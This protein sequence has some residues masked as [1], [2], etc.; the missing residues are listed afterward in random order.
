MFYYCYF[1]E[2]FIHFEVE[3][4]QNHSYHFK[5]ISLA[6]VVLFKDQFSIEEI[7]DIVRSCESEKP[8]GHDKFSFNFLKKYWHFINEDIVCMKFL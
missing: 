8:P 7:K 2:K 4:S 5:M 1:A 3:K 6:Q